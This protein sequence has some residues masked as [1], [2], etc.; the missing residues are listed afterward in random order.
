MDALARELGEQAHFLF[1]YTREAH[2]EHFPEEFPPIDS[3]ERKFANAGVMRHDTPRTVLIDDLDG[4]VHRQF[5]GGSNMAY[6][7]DHTGRLHYKANW[8]REPHL[9]RELQAA[10]AIRELKRTPTSAWCRT[11]TRACPTIPAHG[12]GIASPTASSRALKSGD[13]PALSASLALR[14]RRRQRRRA[15]CASTRTGTSS[16]ARDRATSARCRMRR[17]APR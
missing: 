16:P 13:R 7:V 8:T 12:A 4:A 2:P 9:R 5:S 17:A 14:A 6:I 11:T 1:I 10:I 15:A 3:I